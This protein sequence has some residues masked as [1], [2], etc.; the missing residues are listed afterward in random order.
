MVITSCPTAGDEPGSD[1]VGLRY[2]VSGVRTKWLA[3]GDTRRARTS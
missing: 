1:N 3:S 2:G